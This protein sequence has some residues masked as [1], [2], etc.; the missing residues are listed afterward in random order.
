MTVS[1]FKGGETEAL[2]R[3]RRKVS[4]RTDFV[5]SFRKP[6]TCST[7]EPTDPLEPSTTGLSPYLSVGCLSVRRFWKEVEACNRKSEHSLLRNPCTDNFSSGRCFTSCREPFETGIVT[8]T[9][10]CASQ[11]V[12]EKRMSR[13]QRHGPPDKPD[14]LSSTQ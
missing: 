9:T 4:Q 3:L 10:P 1:P 5:N 11:S 2:I 14:F 7:N 12:G 8:W 6:K 13:S